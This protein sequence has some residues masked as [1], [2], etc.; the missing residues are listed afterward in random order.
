MIG[1]GK[2][3]YENGDYYKGDF[4]NGVFEGKGIFVLVYGWFYIGDFKKG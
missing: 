2:L 1:K 4:V 3:I